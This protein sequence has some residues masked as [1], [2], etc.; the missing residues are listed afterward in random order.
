VSRGLAFHETA[1]LVSLDISAE[2][3]QDIST[4]PSRESTGE[5]S[6]EFPGPIVVF[7]TCNTKGVAP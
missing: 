5:N 7:V 1:D 2:N 3:S 6:Q 4:E